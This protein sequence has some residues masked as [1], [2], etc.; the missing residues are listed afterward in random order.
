MRATAVVLSF[1]AACILP[2]AAN[3]A[4][5]K[6]VLITVSGNQQTCHASYYDKYTVV[7]ENNTL[8]LRSQNKRVLFM[9]V[10]LRPDGSAD[11]DSQIQLGG[12]QWQ[13]VRVKVP[14]GSG[15]RQFDYVNMRHNCSVRVDPI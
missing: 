1:A 5:W 12:S 4:E 14:P 13:P 8:F 6:V 9:T 3:A 15:R 10:P 2:I 11:V 7:E